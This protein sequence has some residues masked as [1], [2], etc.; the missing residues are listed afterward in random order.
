MHRNQQRTSARRRTSIV[1]LSLAV[2]VGTASAQHDRVARPLPYARVANDYGGFPHHSYRPYNY[3]PYPYAL[4]P[5]PSWTFFAPSLG[6]TEQRALSLSP[7]AKAVV[8]DGM[9]GYYYYG[10]TYYQQ[11]PSGFAVVAPTPGMTVENLPRGGSEVRIG[12][13][14]YVQV[15]NTYYQSIQLHGKDAWQVVEAPQSQ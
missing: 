15:G 9:R 14:A 3:D 5:E 1:V 2:A 6:T 4:G 12:A 10:G 11:T 13:R 7:G 8:V